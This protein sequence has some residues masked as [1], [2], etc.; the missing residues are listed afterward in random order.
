[1]LLASNNAHW[2]SAS[3][4]HPQPR[5]V[6]SAHLRGR[7]L[8]SFAA[9][10]RDL[11]SG[12]PVHHNVPDAAWRAVLRFCTGGWFLCGATARWQHGPALLGLS[13]LWAAAGG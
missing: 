2:V 10:F 4:A 11:T 12:L 1:M 9:W 7:T 6:P 5:D 8:Y 3:C 13:L